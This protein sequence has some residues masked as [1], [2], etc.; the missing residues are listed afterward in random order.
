MRG[1]ETVTESGRQHRRGDDDMC[2]LR[3]KLHM[4]QESLKRQQV[5]ARVGVATGEQERYMASEQE[6]AISDKGGAVVE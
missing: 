1:D 3:A 4:F 6:G 5:A 2:A